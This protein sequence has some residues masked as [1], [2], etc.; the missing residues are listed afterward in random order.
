MLTYLATQPL[1]VKVFD[2]I[3]VDTHTSAV[4]VIEALKE[5]DNRTFAA[6]TVTHQRYRL[7]LVDVKTNAF[8]NLKIS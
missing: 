4:D 6:S 8:Q 5:L 1:D 2:V 7:S 3:S